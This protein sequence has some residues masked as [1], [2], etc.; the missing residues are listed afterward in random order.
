MKVHTTLEFVSKAKKIHG[1]QY[2]YSHT[3]YE[4]SNSKVQIICKI[5]DSFMITPDN[6]THKTN[7]QG[8]PKCGLHKRTKTKID[9]YSKKFLDK[10]YKVHG[11]KYDLS[12]SVYIKAKMKIIVICDK[13]KE[14]LISPDKFLS[15]QGCRECGVDKRAKNRSTPEAGKSLLDKHPELCKEWSDSNSINPSEFNPGSNQNVSWECLDCSNKWRAPI[16]ARVNG[17][18]CRVCKKGQMHSSGNNSM[19][20]THPD[21]ARELMKNDYGTSKSLIMGTNFLLPWKCSKCQHE[22]NAAGS[23]RKSGGGCPACSNKVLHIYGRNSM[24]NTHP[25]L[26]LELMPNEHG[27]AGTL[28]AGTHKM[29]PWRCLKC[30]NQWSALGSSRKSGAGCGVCNSGTIHSDG[31]NSMAKTHPSLSLELMPNQFGTV[32]TLIAGTPSRLPWKCSKCEHEWTVSGNNRIAHDNCPACVNQVLHSSGLNSIASK[33]PNISHELQ[34]ND[35]GTADELVYVTH[36]KLPWKCSKCNH[37]WDT[38]GRNRSKGSGCPPCNRGGLHSDGS[39]SMAKTHPNLALELMP[40]K[41]GTAETLIA[42]T[43]HKL[44]WKCK[45]CNYEWETSGSHR[46]L[47]TGCSACADSGYN[48]STV[49]YL[50]IHHYSDGKNNWLKCGIT[51]YPVDRIRSLRSSANKFN[52]EI[53]EIEIEKFDDGGIPPLC[54]RELLDMTEI[55]FESN[56]DIDGKSGFFKYEALDTI[57][58]FIEQRL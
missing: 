33:L 34:K 2:D 51:N 24:A 18:G 12:K 49:G 20:F 6:H 54:E 50:Y 45:I 21:I 56:Y 14:F 48:P 37:K 1:N 9:R 29:L 16:S 35:F 38:T 10:A 36:H 46:V 8:C 41:F 47:G 55:R 4:F 25:E 5:H 42:G 52:I 3:K 26:A 30:E 27:S 28:L 31:R 53:F 22:W 57:N 13:H 7:P 15:G 23:S 39:N 17:R 19:Y 11:E 43:N 40:N 58:K 44:P 32:D